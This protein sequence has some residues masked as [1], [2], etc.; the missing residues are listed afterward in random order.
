MEGHVRGCP[1]R[2]L[3]QLASTHHHSQ[4]PCMGTVPCDAGQCRFVEIIRGLF[5]DH[6]GNTAQFVTR[7][8][9]Q[10]PTTATVDDRDPVWALYTGCPAARGA[11]MDGLLLPA[12]VSW[13]ETRRVVALCMATGVVDPEPLLEALRIRLVETVPTSGFCAWCAF[14]LAPK[15]NPDHHGPGVG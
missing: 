12:S 6:P 5:A 9:Q 13:V 8:I 11:V 4:P 15:Q 14:V 1:E 7:W 3:A 10:R 2:R